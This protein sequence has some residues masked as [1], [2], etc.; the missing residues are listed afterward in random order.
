MWWF[1]GRPEGEGPSL[2]KNWETAFWEKGT[3]GD[4]EA[5]GTG[6]QEP[7]GEGTRRICRG[8]WALWLQQD[9]L[10]S[11][12]RATWRAELVT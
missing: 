3:C 11:E 1:R 2:A 8:G 9:I 6:A 5:A 12:V 7:C 4:P 10:D